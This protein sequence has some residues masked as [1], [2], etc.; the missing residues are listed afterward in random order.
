MITCYAGILLTKCLNTDT[1]M[2]TFPD[3]GFHAF[4]SKGRFFV[5]IFLYLELYLVPIGFLIMEADNLERFFPQAGINVRGH[6]I[7]GKPFFTMVVGL[8]ILPTM[9][10][11]DLRLL[12]YVSMCGFLSAL[13]IVVSIVCVGVDGVGFSRRGKIFDS[14]GI[15]TTLSLFAFCYG[16]HSITPVVYSSM[17]HRN[18]FYKV[19]NSYQ[20]TFYFLHIQNKLLID[21]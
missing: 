20:N 15:P 7:G 10:L 18:H 13:I 19:S 9:W 8:I 11:K 4:G 6:H 21:F 1:S 14:T 3:V 17:R 2:K 16:V 5:S 12:S